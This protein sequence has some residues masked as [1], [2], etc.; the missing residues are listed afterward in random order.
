MGY[1]ADRTSGDPR[2]DLPTNARSAFRAFQTSLT[3]L[4][5]IRLILPSGLYFLLQIGVMTCYLLCIHSPLN[6]FW[7]ALWPG[8]TGERLSHF[9]EHLILMQAVLGRFD[10]LSDILVHVIFQGAIILLVAAAFREN[11]VS[12]GGSFKHSLKRYPHLVITSLLASCCIFAVITLTRALSASFEGAAGK[13]IIALGILLGLVMQA[14][15][16]YALPFILL[17][18]SSFSQAIG[19]SFILAWSSFLKTLLLV[20]LPF[21][22]TIPT[23]LLN[24]KAEII[25]L[26][27]S[28]E[29]MIHIHVI[30]EI[31]RLISTYLITAGATIA[32]IR[33]KKTGRPLAGGKIIRNPASQGRTM[34]EI[35]N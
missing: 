3:L 14:L 7:A 29:F 12:V 19:K 24:Y 35:D 9:P 26:R 6:R 25:S 16:L 13:G 23:M 32:F 8:L 17:R 10:I 33:Q 30:G 22:L 31:M 4:H 34:D 18:G 11:P 5:D 20:G 2:F 28:P 1:T 21:V 15:F 27:L